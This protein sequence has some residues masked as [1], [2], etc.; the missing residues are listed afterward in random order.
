MVTDNEFEALKT[1]VNAIK[2]LFQKT[3]LPGKATLNLTARELVVNLQHAGD[4]TVDLD[5]TTGEGQIMFCA[6][7]DL[8]REPFSETDVSNALDEHGWHMAHGTL[9]PA[10]SRL[11][12]KKLLLKDDSSKPYKYH[13][14][15]KVTFNLPKGVD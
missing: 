13:V 6:I 15:S 3:L 7:K 8:G 4:V 14:P 2:T 1:E 9:S 5:T 10:L 11:G 12:R